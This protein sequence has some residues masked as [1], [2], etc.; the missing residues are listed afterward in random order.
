MGLGIKCSLA[1]W[2]GI[3]VSTVK[4]EVEDEALGGVSKSRLGRRLELASDEASVLC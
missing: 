1:T 2:S 4:D 3:A